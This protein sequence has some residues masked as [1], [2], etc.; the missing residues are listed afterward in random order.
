M[1][2]YKEYKDSGIGWIGEI[3]EHWKL[4]R[5]KS[6]MSMSGYKVGDNANLYT[7]LSLTTN[8]VI[9]RDIESG[10][11]KFPKDFDDYQV[12]KKDELVF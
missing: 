8:G 4:K 3:P 12:V 9:V 5:N 6:F 1:K 11:G 10:K 7:L 2:K